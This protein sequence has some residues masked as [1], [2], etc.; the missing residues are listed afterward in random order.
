MAEKSQ[1]SKAPEP[2]QASP[3][4]AKQI[5]VPQMQTPLN[6]EIGKKRLAPDTT[7]SKG[8]P[9]V[10]QAKKHKS[11]LPPDVEIIDEIFDDGRE[12]SQQTGTASETGIQ[13][14]L[15][16]EVSSFRLPKTDTGDIKKTFINIKTKNE[17]LKMKVYD[18][19][20]KMAPHNQQRLMSAF[21]LSQGKMLMSHFKAKVPKPMS[22]TDYI[23]TNFEVLAKDIHPLDQIELHRQT[24]EMV[25]SSLTNKAMAALTLQDSLNNTTATLKIERASSQAKDNRIKSLEEIIIGL[26]HNP[27]DT[28]GIEA[29]IKKKEDDI[30]ALRKQLKIPASRH[31]QTQEVIKGNSQEEMMELLLNLTERLNETEKELEKALQEQEILKQASAT[32]T[33]TTGQQEQSSQVNISNLNSEDLVKQ[34]ESL[35]L[36][37]TELQE[38]KLQLTKLEGKYDTSKKTAADNLRE[39]KRLEKLVEA[40][41]KDLTL[42]KPLNE[43][44]DILWDN[45]IE[46]IRGI[47]PSIQAIFEQNELVKIAQEEMNKTR[48]ELRG[49]PEHAQ[50]IIQF[51][52]SRTKQQLALLGIEDRTGTVLEAKRVFTKRTFMQNLERKCTDILVD[53]NVFREKFQALLDSELPSPMLTEDQIVDLETYE[54]RI[55]AHAKH[56]A[57]GS[58]GIGSTS[59]S[60][61]AVPTGKSIYEK[62]RNLFHLEHELKYLFPNEPTFY[63]L[64]EADETLRKL[65][66]TMIPDD[67]WWKE[68]LEVL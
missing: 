40:L 20:M 41:Q 67:Q 17:P 38:A 11:D 46:L 19:Y 7:P 48:H 66:R 10:Y 64:T 31:P 65:R 15:S 26:G 14:Q 45:I 4:P 57:I 33:T 27:K 30:A 32:G 13:K 39:I 28:K 50:Q 35:Q 36:K 59:S 63:K 52:N 34:M 61:P 44:N 8:A 12:D 29:L 22:A 37:V 21:D 55:K 3:T 60:E 62:V 9:Q 18:Q 51:L 49:K 6:V 58:T 25:Y 23:R 54:K 16:T 53:I 42:E 1:S 68:M 5:Q 56:T 2:S 24:G 47:W 43:I